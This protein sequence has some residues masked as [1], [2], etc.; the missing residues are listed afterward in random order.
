MRDEI[1]NS[2]EEYFHEA[3]REDVA[4]AGYDP[5]EYRE[6]EDALFEDT[7]QHV[8]HFMMMHGIL[9]PIGNHELACTVLENETEMNFITSEAPVVFANPRFKTERDLTYAGM[10]N[11]GLQVYCPL[12]P[13][14]CLL[15]YDP[16]VYLVDTDGN[17]HASLNDE[18]DAREINHLQVLNTDT[19]V[20]YETSG[21]EAT[22]REVVEEAQ[23]FENWETVSQ[24]LPVG[25]SEDADYPYQPP[26]QLHDVT[27]TPEP[28]SIRAGVE[29]SQ[30]ER[31][32]EI[33]RYIV[34]RLLEHADTSEEALLRAVV[35][36]LNNAGKEF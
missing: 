3:I 25:G 4:A 23:E 12:S 36:M 16:E 6:L 17:G 32:P 8:H 15:I 20:L 1:R 22:I 33:Q 29:F 7:V 28:V 19:F 34:Q 30:R 14:L 13:R 11:G 21:Q 26:H 24:P 31:A 27:P 2:A 5:T 9:A 18:A 35:Y 10:A